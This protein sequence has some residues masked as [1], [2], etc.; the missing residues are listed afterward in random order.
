MA[1]EIVGLKNFDYQA[2]V[3]L[4]PLIDVNKYMKKHK[5]NKVQLHRIFWQG[6]RAGTM[7]TEIKNKYFGGRRLD[8]LAARTHG[9]VPN[10]SKQAYVKLSMMARRVGADEIAFQTKFSALA[11]AY[12][13]LGG[14]VTG[15]GDYTVSLEVLN[16]R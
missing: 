9:H 12:Q 16:V 7:L 1:F 5:K 14:T 8:I 13:Q 11:G 2:A 10:V 15:D 4:A 6:R 3:D